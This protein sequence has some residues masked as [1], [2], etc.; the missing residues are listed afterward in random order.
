MIQEKQREKVNSPTP[1]PT[2]SLPTSI[3][4]LACQLEQCAP[5]EQPPSLS[6]NPPHEAELVTETTDDLGPNPEDLPLE[7]PELEETDD[8]L[9][10]PEENFDWWDAASDVG[11]NRD[12]QE[13]SGLERGSEIRVDNQPIPENEQIE[14]LAE[15]DKVINESFEG[16]G[17]S[18]CSNLDELTLSRIR[19]MAST[20]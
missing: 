17:K 1:K 3:D 5:F 15:L 6:E 8:V 12:E 18:R 10:C 4:S 16:R 11:D 14:L 20:L 19:L 9:R 2:P 13:P 7:D